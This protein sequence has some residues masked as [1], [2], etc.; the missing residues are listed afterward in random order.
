MVR[1]GPVYTAQTLLERMITR[2]DNHATD[3]L[4]AAVGG[5]GAVNRFLVQTGISGQHLDH[6]MATLVRDDGRSTRPARSTPARRAR[7]AR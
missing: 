6:T 4:I 1:P 3:G 5:I 7:R 2:S